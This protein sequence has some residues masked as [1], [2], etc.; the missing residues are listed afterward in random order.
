M[1]PGSRHGGSGG[2]SFGVTQYHP[3]PGSVP[4]AVIT[5]DSTVGD[6]DGIQRR[7]GV[8]QCECERS[9][10]PHDHL[11]ERAG[12]HPGRNPSTVAHPEGP[13]GRSRRPGRHAPSTRGWWRR[14]TAR[15][16]RRPWPGHGNSPCTGAPRGRSRRASSPVTILD[17]YAVIAFLRGEP[18]AAPSDP[19]SSGQRSAHRG[20][21]CCAVSMADCIAAE[22]A[23]AT[24]RSLATADPDLLDVCH[25]ESIDSRPL[26]ASDRTTW[27]PPTST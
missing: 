21:A 12:K 2:P 7:L 23:R 14:R 18:A 13:G 15:Q 5:D 16:V 26:P 10:A 6:L 27:K 22:T 24:G 3:G 9:R 8:T 1:P 25:A 20:R 19:C 17:A 11:A 4:Q